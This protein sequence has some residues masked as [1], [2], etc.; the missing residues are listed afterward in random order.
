MNDASATAAKPWDLYSPRQRTL[1]LFV[2]FLVSTSNYVDRNVISVLL[3]PI[4]AEFGVSDTMLGLLT[5]LS[6]ALFYATLGLPVAR[7]ADRGDRK[8]IITGALVIW[9]SMTVLCGMAQ[10][11]WQL[12]LAR[13]GVG[14][15]EAGAIP[16]AQSLIADYYRPERR[17]RALGVFMLSATAGYVLGISGGGWIAGEYGWR[18]AFMLF[19]APGLLLAIIVWAVLDEPR[20]RPQFAPAKTG[21]E[22]A[23]SA[24]IAL[25]RK[26]SYVN[27]LIAMTLYFLIAY[28]A[29]VFIVSFMIRAHHVD[30]ATISLLYGVSSAIGAIIGN[31]LGGMIADRL[32]ARDISW[33]ATLPGLGLLIAWPMFEVALI[34]PNFWVMFGLIF[35][36]GTFLQGAIPP[37]FSALHAV[38]GERRRATAVAIAF[39][40]ANLIGLG[41]GPVLAGALS[42]AMS[43]HFGSGDGLRYAL[44]IVMCVFLPCGYFLLRAGRHLAADRED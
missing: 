42:D 25:T 29:L 7:W 39:F 21:G 43:V 35:I 13:V 16:P 31:P 20:R 34:S 40:F 28:G 41:I 6:F 22:T 14:A 38:C 27:L 2:L 37:M 30:I 44:M 1:Y 33:L 32:A 11:F 19:G 23:L 17:A 12:A 4:K 5:G 9:S 26:K 8:F 36:A 15:G 3:E 10:N 18:W 24:F